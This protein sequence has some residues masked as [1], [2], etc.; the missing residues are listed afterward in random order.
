M[1]A[2]TDDGHAPTIPDT[3]APTH[4]PSSPGIP[5]A[6]DTRY[7]PFT[8]AVTRRPSPDAYVQ[9]ALVALPADAAARDVRP[10]LLAGVQAF[11]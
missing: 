3:Q 2:M 11:F 4:G 10:V 7:A 5:K 8:T 6:P 9:L 1:V